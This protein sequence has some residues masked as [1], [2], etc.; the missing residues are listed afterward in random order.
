MQLVR[1]QTQNFWVNSN[2]IY[3]TDILLLENCKIMEEK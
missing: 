2:Q 3:F 1:E